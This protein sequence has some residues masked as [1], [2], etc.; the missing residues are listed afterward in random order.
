MQCPPP[1]PHPCDSFGDVHV[2]STHR[3]RL[4]HRPC[5]CSTIFS[6]LLCLC[7]IWPSFALIVWPGVALLSMW[8]S[9]KQCVH[10]LGTCVGQ[11]N[12]QGFL[13]YGCRRRRSLL[14]Q[15]TAAVV[16]HNVQTSPNSLPDFLGK[17]PEPCCALLHPPLLLQAQQ[18]KNWRKLDGRFIPGHCC[19]WWYK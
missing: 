6:A 16:S 12:M 19:S 17:T 5:F 10:R 18:C 9:K 4:T 3:W 14:S 1:P 8:S 13:F 7:G 15:G 2:G 11:R